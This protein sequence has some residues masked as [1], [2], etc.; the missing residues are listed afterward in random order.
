MYISIA[1][2]DVFGVSSL[3]VGSLALFGNIMAFLVIVKTKY[4][5]NRS[6]CF[7]GSLIMT[8]FLVGALLEPMHVAQFFSEELHSN[9]KF[10]TARRYLSKI[11]IGASV[12][13]IA[14]ISY[15]RYTHLSKRNTYLIHMGKRK[16]AGLIAMSWLVPIILP[17]LM[18]LRSD[19]KIYRGIR[20]L[21]EI[22][23]ILIS[24]SFTSTVLCYVF[25][26]KIVRKK[27]FE[28]VQHGKQNLKPAG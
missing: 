20:I 22:L 24:V 16:V 7:L 9:C 1:L 18:K 27:K 8:D 12:G 26:V 15:D 13:S 28:M 11:L 2:R 19:E 3:S 25:I 14:M 17:I 10:N 5:R 4:F 21:S 23:F 6:T